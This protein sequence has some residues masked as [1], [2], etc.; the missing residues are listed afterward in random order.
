MSDSER[1]T[2]LRQNARQILLAAIMTELG[3][4]VEV[5]SPT[6]II[7][8]TNR[9][10]QVLYRFKNEDS[11]FAP[12]QIKFSPDDPDRELWLIVNRKVGDPG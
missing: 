4:V 1:Q 12:I 10:K 8:P 5:G 11:D 6:P 3:I 2:L 9:A 7:Q